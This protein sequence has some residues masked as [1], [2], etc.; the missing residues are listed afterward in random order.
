M[1]GLNDWQR[2]Q[3]NFSDSAEEATCWTETHLMMQL[4]KDD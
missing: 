3:K 1:M 2:S 4:F